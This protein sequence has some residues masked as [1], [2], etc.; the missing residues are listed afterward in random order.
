M[1]KFKI[2]DEVVD[3]VSGLNGYVVK[4]DSGPYEWMG[5]HYEVVLSNGTRTTF[6]EDCLQESFNTNDVFALCKKRNFANYEFAS[7]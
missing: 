1:A 5:V 7:F 4:A 6:E 3:P 2:G